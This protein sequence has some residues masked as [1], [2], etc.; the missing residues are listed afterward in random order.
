MF[1]WIWENLIW[2]KLRKPIWENLKHNLIRHKRLSSNKDSSNKLVEKSKSKF[3]NAFKFSNNNINKFTSLLRNGV[4][5]YEYMD[6][7]EK[8]NETILPLKEECYSNLNME[9]FTD[10]DYMHEKR[11]CKDF[12]IKKLD[13]YHGFYLESDTLLLADVFEN[14]RKVCLKINALALVW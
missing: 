2:E 13:V 4:D 1:S 9:D 6:H 3:K 10:A 7:W 11:V 14:F 8:F 5:P 12:E